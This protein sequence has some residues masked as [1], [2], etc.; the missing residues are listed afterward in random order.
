V[1]AEF[2]L[3]L[4]VLLVD[5]QGRLVSETDLATLLPGAFLPKDLEK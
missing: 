2:G 1:L 5:D 4:T 3:D